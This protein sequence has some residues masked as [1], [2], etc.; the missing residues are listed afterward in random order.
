MGGSRPERGGHLGPFWGTHPE[1]V[2][3]SLKM[4][5]FVFNETFKVVCKEKLKVEILKNSKTFYSKALA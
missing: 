1:N 4:F 3:A 2:H 5:K